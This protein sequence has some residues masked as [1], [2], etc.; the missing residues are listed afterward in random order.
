MLKLAIYAKKDTNEK[1]LIPM[2]E[3]ESAN[4]QNALC[5]Q[6]GGNWLLV[7]ELK[8]DGEMIKFEDNMKY[9]G[10]HKDINRYSSAIKKI[11]L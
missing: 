8:G 7:D 9:Q 10:Y 11:E 4:V 3:W 6:F 5:K 1:I 2:P